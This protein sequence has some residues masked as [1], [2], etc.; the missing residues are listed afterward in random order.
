[1]RVIAYLRVSTEKQVDEGLGMDVQ[2]QAIGSWASK[3]EHLLYRLSC[4]PCESLSNLPASEGGPVD[5]D[6]CAAITA[7]SRAEID[8]IITDMSDSYIP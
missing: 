2:R 8:R 3:K 7:F 5:L 1:M 6:E 4:L